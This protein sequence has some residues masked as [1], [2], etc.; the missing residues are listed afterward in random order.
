MKKF[1]TFCLKAYHMLLCVAIMP[2]LSLSLLSCEPENG[3]AN[4]GGGNEG[5]DSE[6]TTTEIAVTGSVDVYG[7]TYADVSGYANL[8][9]LPAGSG[10]PLIGVEIVKADVDNN[11]DAIQSTATSLIGNLFTV[12]FRNLEPG[13]E[14]KYRSFVTYGGITYYGNKFNALTTKKVVN[15]DSAVEVSEITHNSAVVN[16]SVQ[17]EGVDPKDLAH[18]G[19][20]WSVTR[21]DLFPNGGFESRKVSAQ[22]VSDGVYS[23]ALSNLFPGITYYYASFTEVGG[24]QVLSSVKEFT[25][26][27]IGAVDLGLSIK[28]AVCN[29]G[30]DV[31][32]GY[33]SYYA[34]GET[35]EKSDYYWDTYKYYLDDGDYEVKFQH[36]GFNI[37]GTSYDVARVKWGGS[38]RMPTLDEIKELCN[39]CS[40]SSISLNGVNGYMVTGPNGNSIFLP[41]AGSRYRTEVYGRGSYGDYWSGTLSESNSL[42][43]CWIEF[44]CFDSGDW[45]WGCYSSASRS[46]GLTVRPVTE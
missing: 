39:K 38:W 34:W 16:V 15:I 37:S 8:D 40:W 9:L 18:V 2:T 27:E 4:D 35:E 1:I 26:L 11:D 25:T 21:D 3:D 12:S 19:L 17:T 42:N 10:N 33:G 46:K 7:C 28:W 29:V 20:A 14:Y 45:G 24:V 13:T 41:A 44:Y 30:A 43:A 22:S 6:D 31:P 32:E 36:I 23:V 5:V